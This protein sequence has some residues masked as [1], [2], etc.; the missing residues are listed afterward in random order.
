MDEYD[1]FLDQVSRKITLMELQKYALEPE[2]RGRQFII[3][4]PQDLHGIVS[5]STVK[6]LRMPAPERR[7]R[8][9]ISSEHQTTLDESGFEKN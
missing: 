2:Q 7:A 8:S 1:V 4:T 5:S 6:H 9:A 3:I